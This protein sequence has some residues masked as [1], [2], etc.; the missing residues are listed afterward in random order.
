[1]ICG[2]AV[3]APADQPPS[4]GR[5]PM[6]SVLAAG[7]RS[8]RQRSKIASCQ[9]PAA[10]WSVYAFVLR[11]LGSSICTSAISAASLVRRASRSGSLPVRDQQHAAS[12]RRVD[13]CVGY[14]V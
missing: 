2:E 9:P 6:N 4:G 7:I 14:V 8:G 1:M 5:L 11:K 10:A 13:D 12:P 3:F